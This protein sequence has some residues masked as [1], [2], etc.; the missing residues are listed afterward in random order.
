MHS[1]TVTWLLNA[2]LCGLAQAVRMAL[3]FEGI[4]EK[5]P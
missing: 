1:G 4:E 5:M 3:G 2:A